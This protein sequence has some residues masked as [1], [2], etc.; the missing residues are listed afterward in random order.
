MT[1]TPALWHLLGAYFHQDWYD[2]YAAEVDAI[3]DFIRGS[4]DLAPQLPGE[5]DW[6]L[7]AFA[8]DTALE[9]YLDSQGCEYVP[10][11]PGSYRA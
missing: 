1:A 4:G 3:D 10:Q 2:E 8:D 6:I 5:I 7:E 11:G 9:A